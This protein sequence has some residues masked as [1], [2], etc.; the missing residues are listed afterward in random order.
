VAEKREQLCQHFQASAGNEQMQQQ[1]RV[2]LRAAFYEHTYQT[3]RMEDNPTP[4]EEVYKLLNAGTVTATAA[5]EGGGENN[6]NKADLN[7]I[8]K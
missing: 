5:E 3:C 7:S 2:H 8:H 6:A 4:F 1:I